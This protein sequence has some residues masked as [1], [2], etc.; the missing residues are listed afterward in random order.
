MPD[1]D[2][3]EF[4]DVEDDDGDHGQGGVQGT[5]EDGNG[6]HGQAGTQGDSSENHHDSSARFLCQRYRFHGAQR[7]LG[8]RLEPSS[9][10]QVCTAKNRAD[11]LAGAAHQTV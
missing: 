9:L 6:D 5:H 10:A 4:E 1:G 8:E 11:L 3:N 7:L 2:E